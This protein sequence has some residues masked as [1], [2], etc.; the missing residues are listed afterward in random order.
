PQVALTEAVDRVVKGVQRRQAD[1]VQVRAQHGL[2]RLLPAR[3][4]PQLFGQ[5]R[6]TVE[7]LLAQPLLYAT[8]LIQR[9]LL[10]RLQ[11][12]QAPTL[13]LDLTAADILLL[14]QRSEKV[15]FLGQGIGQ[16]VKTEL[17]ALT[18]HLQFG[19][20]LVDL[21]Q[22]S[23]ERAGRQPGPLLL[24]ALDPLTEALDAL[25]K[26]TYARLLHFRLL[27]RRQGLLVELVPTGLPTL[28]R[29]FGFHQAGRI[30]LVRR[31]GQFQLRLDGIQLRTQITEQGLVLDQ[32]ALRLLPG[33]LGLRQIITHLALTVAVELQH[34]FDAT[35]V[36]TDAVIARLGLIETLVQLGMPV[37][38]FLD[39]AV[40]VALLGNDRLQCHF[41]AAN[42]VFALVGPGIQRLP[43]QRLQL[44]LQLALFG[45][46]GLV[47]L[48][49]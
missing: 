38:L 5:Q 13:A 39:L 29:R 24:Q 32:V 11:R 4:H 3:L 9:C 15:T 36:R 25:L 34:L 2:H 40:G 30:V 45:L 31:G 46:E 35:D 44:G 33:L 49:G 18:A 10:Q 19:Q 47:L 37:A 48:C 1:G 26:V 20:L 21:F 14:R 43:A 12:S 23:V 6:G 7:A 8:A 17:V 28:H 22:L 41:Q 16:V 42:L 27:A